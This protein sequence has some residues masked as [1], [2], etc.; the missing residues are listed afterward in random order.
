MAKK[1]KEGVKSE[2]VFNRQ[3]SYS[4]GSVQLSFTLRTDIKEEMQDFLELLNKATEDVKNQL[5]S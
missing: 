5:E 4:N 1:K 3:F 2:A